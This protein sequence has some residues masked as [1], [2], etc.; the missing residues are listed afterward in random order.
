MKKEIDSIKGLLAIVIFALSLTAVLIF[1]ITNFDSEP[2]IIKEIPK[3]IL[4]EPSEENMRA[5]VFSNNEFAFDLYSFLNKGEG[6]NIFYSPYSVFSAL[7]VTYEGSREKTAEEIASVLHLP[8]E[9]VLRS[10]FGA[11]YNQI[12]NEE[13]EYELNAANALWAQKDYPFLK[14]YIDIIQQSYGGEITNLD[15]VGD[16]ESSRKTINEYIEEKTNDKIKNLI[17]QGALSSLTRMVITNAIYFKG[18]WKLEFDKEDTRELDFYITPENSVKTDMMFMNPKETEFNYLETEEIQVIELPYQGGEVSMFVLLPKENIEKIESNLDSEKLREYK[19]GMKKTEID[20]IYLPKFEFDTKY[21]MKETLI[22]MGIDSAF[23]YGKADFSKMDGTKELV[24]D[25]VIHQAYVGVDEEG[26]EAAGATAVIIGITS[27]GPENEKIFMANR[28]FIFII[29]ENKTE[30]I[31]FVGR[32]SN[33][34]K[35]TN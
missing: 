33:P 10:G 13:K 26:T 14:E 1:L 4:I 25:N 5:V 11:L 34:T 24:I 9:G 28:P 30:N 20:G 29:Q 18:K 23:F 35:S 19:E 8:E 32:V 21:F 17:P 22:S 2:L 3:K 15:F 12:N 27:I 6:E 7:T 31:L 16:T